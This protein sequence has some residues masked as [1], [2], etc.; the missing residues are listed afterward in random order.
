MQVPNNE[1]LLNDYKRI[2]SADSRRRDH[3]VDP[4]L[5]ANKRL[6]ARL[7]LEIINKKAYE[8]ADE[9]FSPDF[10]WPQFELHGPDGVRA[11][12]RQ[13]HGA[14]ADV[15]DVLEMQIAEGD[16]VVSLLTVYGTQT[17]TWLGFPPTHKFVVFPAIGI[18]RVVN[19]KIVERS[20]T[21]NTVDFMRAVGV[22][23]LPDYPSDP[24]R[25]KV[26]RR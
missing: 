6:V 5:E 26:D 11:W 13:F 3:S 16:M 4:K 23:H 20:A 22:G 1:V 2:L 8:V 7:F 9:I 15:Q 12:M 24:A 14:F 10:Y 17:G 25:F 18:D 19:G 21:S